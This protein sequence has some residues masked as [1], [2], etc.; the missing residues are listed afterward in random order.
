MNIHIKSKEEQDKM[1]AAGKLAAQTL[2]MIEPHVQVGITTEELNTLVHD[3]TTNSGAICAPLNYHGFP[4]SV[5]ISINDV[6]CHG[7]PDSR[8][9]QDGDILNIDVSPKLDG[10]VGDTSKMFLVGDVNDKD[11]ELCEIAH[12]DMWAGLKA[13]IPGRY[14]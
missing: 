6:A 2:E 7:I 9:L 10:W 3:F 1:R 13:I 12:G 4:K 14:V 8:I 5:C 11:R